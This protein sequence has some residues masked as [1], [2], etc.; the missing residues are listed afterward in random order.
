MQTTVSRKMA[1]LSK[2]VPTRR[3]LIDFLKIAGSVFLCLIVPG[4]VFGVSGQMPMIPTPI[5][6][7]N[8]QKVL[9]GRTFKSHEELLQLFYL[10]SRDKKYTTF[11]LG[12]ANLSKLQ[13]EITTLFPLEGCEKI[14]LWGAYVIF[15]FA[16]PQDVYIPNTWLQ[17][18]LQV[19]RRLVLQITDQPEGRDRSDLSPFAKDPDTK[20]VTFSVKEGYIRVHF[21]F[22]LRLFGGK[23]RDADG[24]R[25]IYQINDKTKISRLQLDEVI[26][27]SSRS[28][29]FV[30]T[31]SDKQWG[32]TQWIDIIHPDFPATRDIGI[33]DKAIFFLGTKVE[34]LSNERIRIGGQEAR[35]NKEAWD[36]FSKNIEQFRKFISAGTQPARIEYVR[37]FGYYLEERRFVMKMSFQGSEK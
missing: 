33:S 4:K 29:Q 10:L 32:K 18:S 17:A 26:P 27:L 16:S 5:V 36:W 25:L 34:L 15:T 21:S 12:K 6:W 2:Q 37:S 22:L 19:P 30:G 24:T 8:V 14:E 23:L 13:K 9:D 28:L 1:P 31:T 11:S 7:E 35:K 20:T 3:G